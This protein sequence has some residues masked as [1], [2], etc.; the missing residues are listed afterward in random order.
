MPRRRCW[1]DSPSACPPVGWGEAC[2]TAPPSSKGARSP[3]SPA[4]PSCPPT[5]S[6]T[7]GATSTRPSRFVRFPFRGRRL[8]VSICE[9]IWN[10]ADFWPQR[11]YRTDP[12]ESLVAGGAEIIVNVSA[13]PYTIEKRRLRPRMLAATARRWRRP[14]VFVNQVGGQDDLV[15]D[16]ASLAFDAAGGVLARGREHESDLVICDIPLGE[17]VASA[18]G[19]APARASRT[20]PGSP[21]T[22]DGLLRS[23]R[24]RVRAG[25]S[26][27]RDAR[28]R[29]ALR[30][31]ARRCSDFRAASIRR[32]SPAS[33]PGPW[34]R[35]TSSGVAMPSRY[36]SAGS[37]R[38]RRSA[39]AQPGHRSFPSSPSSRCSRRISGR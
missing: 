35:G 24:R 33:R 5:M 9:D 22:S 4:S 16:G 32:W 25:G 18:A 3:T 10:D 2:R 19:T 23:G 29:A 8:G 21:R 30:I 20:R 28:L 11:L 27:A 13:S 15:F 26:R 38:R 1:W 31:F 6:S 17:S 14:L 12:I 7:N 36:S 34:V 37:L 39:G